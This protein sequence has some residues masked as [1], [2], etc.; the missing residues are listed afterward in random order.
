L[1][2]VEPVIPV[3]P[4]DPHTDIPTVTVPPVDASVDSA[5]KP[6][7]VA[8][9]AATGTAFVGGF[10]VVAVLL[11]A[12]GAAIFFISRRRRSAEEEGPEAKEAKEAHYTKEDHS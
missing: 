5:A 2:P 1:I 4:V 3:H 12:G 9:L 8:G 11:L 10:A 6:T 7:A